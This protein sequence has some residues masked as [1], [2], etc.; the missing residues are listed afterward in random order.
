MDLFTQTKNNKSLIGKVLVTIFGVCLVL[1][2]VH[3]IVE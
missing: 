2:I 3:L 1:G